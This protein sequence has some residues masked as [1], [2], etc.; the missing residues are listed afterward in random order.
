MYIVIIEDYPL[1]CIEQLQ[2]KYFDT[3]EQAN[4]FANKLN[5]QEKTEYFRPTKIKVYRE[6]LEIQT[7]TDLFNYT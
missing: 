3:E 7:N 4:D 5:D 6:L 1:K 2:I